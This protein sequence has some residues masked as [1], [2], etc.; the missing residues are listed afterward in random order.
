[1]RCPFCDQTDNRVVDSRTA[2]DGSAIRRRRE[3]SDCERRFTTYERV[4]EIYPQIIK[5]DGSRED[6]DRLKAIRGIRLACSKRPIS[7]NTIDEVVDRVERQML[8]RG[9][10]EIESEW[11]GAAIT[12][13]LREIDPIAYI[14]FASVYRGFSD[15]EDFIRVLRELEEASPE[16]AAAEDR[17]D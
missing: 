1:M 5:R 10:R 9:D 14:R 6:Y 12:A 7:T 17:E 3:C 4:E 8:D 13:E 16:A 2:R 11:I 15:S